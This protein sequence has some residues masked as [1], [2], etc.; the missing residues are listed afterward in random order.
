[1]QELG[2][3]WTSQ[4]YTTGSRTIHFKNGSEGP[5]H[6]PYSYTEI[7][8]YDIRDGSYT[9]L[10]EGLAEFIEV[11]DAQGEVHRYGHEIPPHY[12]RLI[13]QKALGCTLASLQRAVCR[14][15]S[16]CSDCGGTDIRDVEGFPGETYY[17]CSDCGEVVGSSFNNG[18]IV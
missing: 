6:D 3:Y 7:E 12:Q 15:D 1:M 9:M 17:Q 11:S 16:T 14:S 13:F 4:D 5:S 8:V 18:A 2:D 10:H